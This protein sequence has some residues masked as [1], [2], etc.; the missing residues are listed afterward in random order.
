MS[1]AE[2]TIVSATVADVRALAE[3]WRREVVDNGRDGLWFSPYDPNED[4]R[5]VSDERIAHITAAIQRPL[6]EP[7]WQRVW[8]LRRT[9]KP[10]LVL[11][12]L[13]LYGGRLASELHRCGLGM[14]IEPEH[15]GRRNGTAMVTTALEW[16]RSVETLAWVDLGVFDGNHR[17]RALYERAGFVLVGERRDAFRVRDVR[18]TDLSM[19]LDL[20]RR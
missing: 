11:G 16:A 1:A 18:I 17:A 10:E 8:V 2:Y 4:A 3:H 20:G 14:G 5:P 9:D 13:S 6:T 19:T 12:S 15:R 7:L